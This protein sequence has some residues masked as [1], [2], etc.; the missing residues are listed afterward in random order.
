MGKCGTGALHA[1]EEDTECISGGTGGMLKGQGLRACL[2]YVF[3]YYREGISFKREAFI[4][5]CYFTN[6]RLKNEER[7]RITGK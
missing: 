1:W 7:A 6:R 3:Q 5:K 2:M 4:D